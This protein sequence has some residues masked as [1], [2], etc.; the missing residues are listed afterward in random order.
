LLF[1]PVLTEVSHQ[2]TTALTSPVEFA[3]VQS[4]LALQRTEAKSIQTML[5]R[6][7][8]DEHDGYT[9]VMELF[10]GDAVERLSALKDKVIQADAAFK[11]VSTF[12]GESELSAA[13][14]NKT[15][16]FFA[17]FKTFLTSWKVKVLSWSRY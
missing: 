8:M 15:S 13:G 14:Q 4:A 16:A 11:D 2:S 10:I 7:S 6:R 5:E 1:L 3:D 9:S 12:Y 17:I